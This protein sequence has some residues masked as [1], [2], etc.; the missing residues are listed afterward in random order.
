ML[1][2]R[3]DDVITVCEIK[4]NAK[5]FSIDKAYAQNLQNK[6]DVYKK[7]SKTT[8]QLFLAMITVN[9]LKPSLYSEEFIHGIVTLDDL[10]L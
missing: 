5:P 8:K 7:Q 6:L 3:D 4:Y 10:F 1:F 9:G 2:D